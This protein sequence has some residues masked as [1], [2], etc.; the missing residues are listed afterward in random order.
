MSESAHVSEDATRRREPEALEDA[1]GGSELDALED[2]VIRCRGALWLR[3]LPRSRDAGRH[4]LAR[5]AANRLAKRPDAGILVWQVGLLVLAAVL[6]VV[7]IREVLLI[8][9]DHQVRDD[10]EQEMREL[11]RLLTG[12]DP[13]TGLPFASLEALFNVYL[14]RNVPSSDEAF[15][16]FV[17]GDLFR[18]A[19][20]RFPLD[21]LPTETLSGWEARASDEPGEGR[22]ANGRFDTDIGP[23]YFRLAR[24]SIGDSTGAFVVA[25]LP[26]EELQDIGELQSLG[27]A[28]AVGLLLLASVAAWLITGRVLAPVRSLTETAESISRS[29]LT[30]RIEVT[31][32]AEAADMARSFNA[33]LDR[34]EAVFRSQR[35][36]VQDTSHELR[37]PLTICRGTLELLPDDPEERAA[38][39]ALVIDEI[40]RMGRIV[41]DLQVLADSEHPDFVRSEPIDLTPFT[42]ELI[43]KAGALAAREWKLDEAANGV[44]VADRWALTEAVMN[45]ANNAVEHTQPSDT[46]SI[47]SSTDGELLRLWVRDT[48]TGIPAGRPVAHLRP[49][50]AWHRRAPSIP[51]ERPRPRDRQGHRRGTRRPC[52]P[53]EPRRRRLDVHAR[54]ADPPRSVRMSRILIAEDDPLIGYLPREG[55]QGRRLHDAARGRRGGGGGV[56][57][58]G[59]VRPRHPRHGPAR[60]GRAPC[61]ALDP[62]PGILV[63]V[64]VLTGRPERDVVMCLDAGA[65]DYMTKP[66]RFDEL[67]ARVR[68]RLRTN[69]AQ[70]GSTLTAGDLR[71]DLRTRRATVG[72]RTV[73][74]TAREFS[75]LEA[76]LRHPDQVLSREQLLSQVWGY[77]FD[78]TTNLVNVYVNALRKKLGADVIETVR[79]AG[80]RVRTAPAVPTVREAVGEAR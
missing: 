47:G 55:P 6:A 41:N 67:L 36:F 38:S 18:S 52:R 57:P 10:L 14:S 2:G 72:D 45:L 73:E 30:R 12:I 4:R 49:I 79:G 31:G 40:D 9:L 17:E 58:D 62:G 77:Y 60:Q 1:A 19:V 46:V 8:R 59:R 21:V 69:R 32:G 56:L 33:M 16:A 71:L 26:A 37:D 80:Y 25:I 5:A 54:P 65:D 39:V 15:L 61:P 29:D 66:F 24:V 13:Q 70:Q 64:M 78:P 42:H 51:R 11:D 50:P 35:E 22:S 43:A 74:L 75:L 76:L 34:L 20:A 28:G 3:P 27:A 48:G 68:T 23:V 63:P 53:R 44:L 7:A